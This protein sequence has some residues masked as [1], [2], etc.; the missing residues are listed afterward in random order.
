MKY[1]PMANRMTFIDPLRGFLG[2]DDPNMTKY[3]TAK[4]VVQQLP[5]ELSSS[6]VQG[7]KDGPQAIIDASAFVEFYDEELRFEPCRAGIATQA[8]LDFEGLDG[9]QAIDLIQE[10]TTRHLDAG[11]FVV[12][13]GAEHT[14]TY[15]IFKA[16]REK[17]PNVSILQIDAHADL[18]DT[19]EG[20]MLSHACVMARIN[21]YR[22]QICQVG[23]RAI[24][25]EEAELIDRSNNIQTFYG[26]QLNDPK[27][28]DKI[29]KNLG[30]DVYITIDTDGFDPSVMPAAGTIEPGGLN[31]FDALDIFKE[32]CNKKNVVGF[33]IVECAPRP[34]DVQTQYNLA[35][36]AY[37]IIGYCLKK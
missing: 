10:N 12:S 30:D 28:I 31:W 6:Y 1:K 11:K 20:N 16:Y 33:D 21:T 4:V 3:D 24:C 14:V 19:Y 9:P 18:R 37:K 32:V 36:L 2:L 17:Y 22:P 8:A 26:Y 15:G 7:S 27:L 35:Q 34:G 29:I 5:F 23:I 25:K 13:L